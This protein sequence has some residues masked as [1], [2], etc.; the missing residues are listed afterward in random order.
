RGG[1][2]S[3]YCSRR[4]RCS[5]SPPARRHSASPGAGRKVS[6]THNSKPAVHWQ[7]FQESAHSNCSSAVCAICLGS[8]SHNFID[9]MAERLWDNK[10]QIV[11][12]HTNR[13]LTLRGSNKPLCVDW[14]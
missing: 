10:F 8:H 5:A 1:H 12:T 13:S 4:S 11:T 7:G 3:N 9:C 14:Q 6:G 2:S